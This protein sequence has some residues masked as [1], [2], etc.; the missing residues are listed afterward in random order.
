MCQVM[1]SLNSPQDYWK[2]EMVST[3]IQIHKLQEELERVTLENSRLLER[4]TV[5]V[6]G[7]RTTG[8]GQIFEKEGENSRLLWRYGILR[9]WETSEG[10]LGLSERGWHWESR[11]RK[12]EI[13]K[14]A[15]WQ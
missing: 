11:G 9:R 15:G 13:K 3:E 2:V 8:K 7:R 1:K 6:D 12:L 14:K 4:S 5:S 10:V